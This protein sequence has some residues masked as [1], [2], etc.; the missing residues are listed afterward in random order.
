MDPT[1]YNQAEQ[2]QIRAL[3]EQKQ[4]TDFMDL[5]TRLTDRCFK[6]C[7]NDFT[8]KAVSSR[9]EACVKR[10]ADRFLKHSERVSVRFGELSET[11]NQASQQQQ[12]N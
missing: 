4:I 11:L 3:I 1:K 6:E 8:S 7:A 12:Q 2:E 5:F 10:C 9:E